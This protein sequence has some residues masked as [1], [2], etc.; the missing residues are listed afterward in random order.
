MLTSAP[1]GIAWGS[2]PTPKASAPAQLAE[3]TNICWRATNMVDAYCN[4]TLRATLDVELVSGPNFRLTLDATGVARVIT[5]RWPVLDVVSARVSPRAAFPRSWQVLPPSAALPEEPPMT[6]GSTVEGAAGAG[7]AAV[8]I[9]PGYVTWYGGRGG[10]LVELS[11]VNGWPHSGLTVNAAAGV[12]TLTVDDVTGFT[13]ASAFLYDGGNT[14]TVNVTSVAA[15]SP[16]TLPSGAV[17][18]VGPGTL[19]LASPT[20][21]PHRAGVACSSI[22]QDVSW[23]TVLYGAAQALTRG[24]TAITAQAMPG[25]QVAGGKSTDELKVEAEI[26]L[27]PYRRIL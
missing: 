20:T 14:E 21:F 23:A 16:V 4:Q 11:Y 1:T 9:A 8:L 2:I 22:P 5:S 25:S 10:Y 6:F 17:V 3:Q 24:S 13:G 19:T 15:T 27:A 12:T 26:L 7:G 18:P